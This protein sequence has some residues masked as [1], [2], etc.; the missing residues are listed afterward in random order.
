MSTEAFHQDDPEEG[1]GFDGGG[2]FF[3]TDSQIEPPS[4][5]QEQ[6]YARLRAHAQTVLHAAGDVVKAEPVPNLS[7]QVGE[8]ADDVVEVFPFVG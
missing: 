5:Y 8:Q 1:H 3:G 6:F 4:T 7:D 2:D